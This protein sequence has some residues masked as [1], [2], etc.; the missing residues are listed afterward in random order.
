MALTTI[1]VHRRSLLTCCLHVVIIVVADF[2]TLITANV[3]QNNTRQITVQTE[4]AAADYAVA[5]SKAAEM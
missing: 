1:G 3:L 4:A 5:R 2:V